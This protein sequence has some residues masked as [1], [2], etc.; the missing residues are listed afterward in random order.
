MRRENRSYD[1]MTSGLVLI[2]EVE[3]QRACVKAWFWL[4]VCGG[5]LW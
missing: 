3:V 1:S 4:I 5:A 2:A